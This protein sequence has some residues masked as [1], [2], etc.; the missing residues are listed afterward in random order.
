VIAYRRPDAGGPP[1][2]TTVDNLAPLGRYH[3]RLKTH[4]GWHCVQPRPGVY[5]WR[6]PHGHWVQVDHTGT[7]PLRRSPPTESPPAETVIERHLRQLLAA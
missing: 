5:R 2:Q 1:G 6:T 3:H 4:G 7:H